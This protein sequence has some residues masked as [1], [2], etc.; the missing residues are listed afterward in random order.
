MSESLRDTITSAVESLET[1]AETPA[2]ETPAPQVEA[3]S[4]ETAP[5]ADTRPRDE[6]GRFVEKPKES[7]AQAP[8]KAAT[9][10][11]PQ[12]QAQAQPAT[13]AAAVSKINRPS[14]WKKDHWEAFDQ[15]AQTN[16]ALAA[17]IN[18]R[19]SEY[20]KGVSTYKQEWEQ[21]KP[22]IDAMAPFMPLLQQH[23]IQPAQWIGNLG[24]AHQQL[25][26]GTPEQKLGMFIR[27]AGDY[28]VPLEQLF[29]KGQDGQV[30]FNQQHVQAAQMQQQHQPQQQQPDVQ[31]LVNEAISAREARGSIAAMESDTE[32]YPH[33]VEVRETMAGLLQAGLANGLD[34]A[35]KAALQHPKHFH[36][37]EAQQKQQ[38]ETEERERAEANRKA[39]EAARRKAV[40]PRTATPTSVASGGEGKKTLRDTISSAL[41]ERVGGR[42]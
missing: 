34:D 7:A 14:T 3:T 19:E 6:Q 35:Y 38:R 42:L 29:V 5:P 16:P 8:A 41:D 12:P 10:K 32:K 28:G 1:P 27:L 24:R 23:Q 37:F 15:L 26:M 39:A 22:L 20:A 30:Y 4:V 33:F 9:A 17:Y 13:P 11:G 40:S 18:Q 21:A 36:L 25:A 31:A 2:V